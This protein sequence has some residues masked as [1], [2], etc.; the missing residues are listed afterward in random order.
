MNHGSLPPVLNRSGSLSHPLSSTRDKS[1]APDEALLSLSVSGKLTD[2]DLYA[3]GAMEKGAIDEQGRVLFPTEDL[4]LDGAAQ[5]HVLECWKQQREGLL[6]PWSLHALLDPLVH[7]FASSPDTGHRIFQTQGTFSTVGAEFW[8]KALAQKIK[9]LG[10]EGFLTDEMWN[11]CAPTRRFTFWF[12]LPDAYKQNLRSF[13]FLTI[14]C[15]LAQALPEKLVGD[16]A[17]EEYLAFIKKEDKPEELTPRLA[18]LRQKCDEAASLIK[19]CQSQDGSQS[20]YA[21]V[22]IACS[23]Q[24][25]IK[26]IFAFTE[27][28]CEIY[29]RDH[30][31]LEILPVEDRDIAPRLVVNKDA[32]QSLHDGVVN[33]MQ[34]PAALQTGYSADFA[35]AQYWV[36]QTCGGSVLDGNRIENCLLKALTPG[37]NRDALSRALMIGERSLTKGTDALLAYFSNAWQFLKRHPELKAPDLAASIKN[38]EPSTPIGRLIHSDAFCAGKFDHLLQIAGTL[39]SALADANPQAPVCRQTAGG[40]ALQISWQTDSVHYLLFRCELETALEEVS[41][42]LKQNESEVLSCLSDVL[43]V[44]V[45][46]R[47]NGHFP[48]AETKPDTRLVAL[49]RSLRDHEFPLAARRFFF[50]LQANGWNIIDESDLLAVPAYFAAQLSG[51]GPAAKKA[52]TAALEEVSWSYQNTRFSSL[53]SDMRASVQT[54]QKPTASSCRLAALRPLMLC[55]ERTVLESAWKQYAQL[56]DHLTA[57]QKC[58]FLL[59]IARSLSAEAFPYALNRV[60]DLARPKAGLPPEDQV[61]LFCTYLD[62]LVR[63]APHDLVLKRAALGAQEKLVEVLWSTVDQS[64][65]LHLELLSYPSLAADMF[66]SEVKL[67]NLLDCLEKNLDFEAIEPA[68]WWGYCVKA[69]PFQARAGKRLDGIFLRAVKNSYEQLAPQAGFSDHLTSLAERLFAGGH[70]TELLALLEEVPEK[71]F[72]QTW[73]RKLLERSLAKQEPVEQWLGILTA[74]LNPGYSVQGDARP[75]MLDVLRAFPPSGAAKGVE[76]VHGLAR[77]IQPTADEVPDLLDLYLTYYSSL[78][79]LE[80]AEK[81]LGTMQQDLPYFEKRND[82]RIVEVVGQCLTLI[83]QKPADNALWSKF[84]DVLRVMH[85]GDLFLEDALQLLERI[86]SF[87]SKQALGSASP[88]HLC[89][90]EPVSR[91]KRLTQVQKTRLV[92]AYLPRLQADG[93]LV[94]QFPP[95]WFGSQQR[96]LKTEESWKDYTRLFLCLNGQR[97]VTARNLAWTEDAFWITERLL[98]SSEEALTSAFACALGGVDPSAIAASEWKPFLIRLIVRAPQAQ[99]FPALMVCAAGAES[100]FFSHCARLQTE[101]MQTLMD[102]YQKSGKL[103][104]HNGKKKTEG[105]A[106]ETKHTGVEKEPVGVKQVDKQAEPRNGVAQL[107]KAP[108]NLQKLKQALSLLNQYSGD[109]FELWLQFLKVLRKNANSPLWEQLIELSAESWFKKHPPQELKLEHSNFWKEMICQIY[110][111]RDFVKS[112]FVHFLS[113][114]AVHVLK[115]VDLNECKYLGLFCLEGAIIVAFN[116]DDAKNTPVLFALNEVIAC[117]AQRDISPMS[118]L[119]EENMASLQMLYARQQDA[120]LH[121]VGAGWLLRLIKVC[122]EEDGVGSEH[123]GLLLKNYCMV[124]FIPRSL[125]GQILMFEWIKKSWPFHKSKLHWNDAANL[126]TLLCGFNFNA[127]QPAQ[128]ADMLQQIHGYWEALHHTTGWRKVIPTFNAT[129][130]HV[131]VETALFKPCFE[132]ATMV[133]MG[134]LTQYSDP[135]ID[136]LGLLY[137]IRNHMPALSGNLVTNKGFVGIQLAYTLCVL[138]FV[139]THKLGS[140]DPLVRALNDLLENQQYLKSKDTDDYKK[141]AQRFIDS[142]PHLL[143]LDEQVIKLTFANAQQMRAIPWVTSAA[144]KE[145][146]RWEKLLSNLCQGIAAC[147]LERRAFVVGL[148]RDVFR[149]CT[150]PDRVVGIAKKDDFIKRSTLCLGRSFLMMEESECL[151]AEETGELVKGLSADGVQFALFELLKESQASSVSS[152]VI[153]CNALACA[154][155]IRHT[156][157]KNPAFLKR[158]EQVAMTGTG[159]LFLQSCG[160]EQDPSLRLRY[161]SH[162]IGAISSL[163]EQCKRQGVEYEKNLDGKRIDLSVKL[164]HSLSANVKDLDSC[165]KYLLAPRF[166]SCLETAVSIYYHFKIDDS[167]PPDVVIRMLEFKAVVRDRIAELEQTLTISDC[168]ALHTLVQHISEEEPEK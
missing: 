100:E 102:G 26:V 14:Y 29:S 110:Q 109:E 34:I 68:A 53:F 61:C 108:V 82:R 21:A 126:V 50:L 142:I 64:Q 79:T 80:N 89:F 119:S 36:Q 96:Y 164:A 10:L 139:F 48:T 152:K 98:A 107:L 22:E 129:G 160:G 75:L 123:N 74:Y 77:K 143:T 81:L 156:E 136:A 38:I 103:P 54:L 115:R 55:G 118:L 1:A 25:A 151:T 150:H 16:A 59:E 94:G 58:A 66:S 111:R 154:R 83:E 93:A 168:M 132:K 161:F 70:D 134:A 85:G 23:R 140:C 138:Y 45:P 56:A 117:L 166:T 145:E 30:L 135:A 31:R 47:S 17:L 92:M 52:L 4:A 8:K 28:A 137:A 11:F 62:R 7:F 95:E 57:K 39:Q 116:S 76:V 6:F 120:A 91:L 71:K 33:R 86:S 162:W 149:V 60:A 49:Y 44:L 15:W 46:N 113:A 167:L 18:E 165:N 153:T 9:P 144:A 90:A 155:L 141:L 97:K 105:A 24:E 101:E 128:R 27:E 88:P 130:V 20:P 163:I 73:H 125:E 112:S 78:Q 12:L 87:C 148:A 124:P 5:A 133:L 37:D 42:A 51:S 65:I 43:E 67:D 106:A 122:L 19:L 3:A 158:L 121:E 35:L 13:Q 84:T 157:T 99:L 114:H 146:Y 69:A 40:R 63:L 104:S 159:D 131:L 41:L 72:S 32:W 127:M 2:K 147:P